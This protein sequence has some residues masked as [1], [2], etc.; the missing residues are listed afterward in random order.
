ML[1]RKLSR[2]PTSHLVDPELLSGLAILPEI[3]LEHINLTQLREDMISA[4]PTPKSCAP[5]NVTI[6]TRSVPGPP[7]AP[8]IRILL[9]RPSHVDSPIPVFIN[10]HGGGY[11]FGSA[12]EMA[13]ENCQIVSE[14]ACMIV[15]PDYRL[16]PETCA[17][18]AL[19]DCYAVLAWVHNSADALN[20]DRD[21]I[22]VGG[23]SAGGGLA[24]SLAQLARDRGEFPLCFQMLVYPMLDDRTGT[25][26]LASKDAMAGQFVWT[27]KSNRIGWRAYLGKEPGHAEIDP[28]SA[29]AR[30]L[31]LAGLPP[32]Y[33]DVGTLDLFRDECIDYASRLLKAGVNTELHVIP[34]AYHAFDLGAPEASVSKACRAMRVTALGNA[35]SRQTTSQ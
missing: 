1:E 29:A 4:L 22:A 2:M 17:P 34:G 19:L 15:S 16:A 31:D 27:G 35:F 6:E 30:Q 33:I 32:A 18:G 26:D 25:V 21:R 28:Y 10:I 24:A 7:G 8:D 12:E 5:P 20:L 14:L 9:Y 13:S 3:D 23:M 11:M